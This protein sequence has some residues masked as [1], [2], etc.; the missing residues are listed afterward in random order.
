MADTLHARLLTDLRD[1]VA[2]LDLSAAGDATGGVGPDAVVVQW[3]RER[4]NLPGHPAVVL[5][6]EGEAED[7]PDALASTELRGATYPVKI[8]VVD[9][10]RHD[11]QAA[12]ADYL[13][14]R[15]AIFSRLQD[16]PTAA[17]AASPPAASLLPNAPECAWVEVKYLRAEPDEKAGVQVVAAVVAECLCTEA[18]PN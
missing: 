1:L 18:R 8:E 17:Q 12:R 7:A 5:S 15:H 11:Y 9:Q 6:C 13:A 16:L 3:Q 10:G 4:Q 14:W 2:A